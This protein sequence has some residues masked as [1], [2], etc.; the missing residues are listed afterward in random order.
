MGTLTAWGHPEFTVAAG[1][2]MHAAVA[3]DPGAPEVVCVHGLGCSHRYFGPLARELQPFCRLSAPDLPGFGRTLGPPEALD[4][5]GMSEAL[6]D[7]LRATDRGGSLLVANSSGCQVVVDLAVHAPEL[8]GPV[9]LNGPTMDRHARTRPRQFLRV[10]INMPFER[11][12][13]MRIARDYYD[14]GARRVLWTFRLLIEDP[15]ER[16][17][18][19]VLTPAVVV[20]G[21]RDPIAP[22]AWCAE[23][24]AGL[25][26][27]SLVEVPGAGHTVNYSEP[28][29][30]ADV[31][32]MLLDRHPV[33]RSDAA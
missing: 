20:R 4:V 31:V 5:R 16:K 9:V 24:A 14:A 26:Q 15:V 18:H 27:G 6:A 12:S 1:T 7:W 21:G 28:R 8:L 13:L 25:P 3:G 19:H 17:L 11:P 2:R 30:L 32:R 29:P 10:L 22:T 23:F 33:E